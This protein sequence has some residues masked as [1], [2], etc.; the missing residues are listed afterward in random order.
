[1]LKKDGSGDSSDSS[2]SAGSDSD[3]GE[4]R[5]IFDLSLLDYR[6]DFQWEKL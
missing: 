5:V 4:V 1:M 3:E 2:S 6:V